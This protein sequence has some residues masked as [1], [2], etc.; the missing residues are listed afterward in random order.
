[1]ESPSN[2]TLLDFSCVVLF[3]PFEPEPTFISTMKT[4]DPKPKTQPRSLFSCGFF[5]QWTP[6][7]P[8][9]P[10]FNGTRHS[11]SF[12]NI[13]SLGREINPL[14][15]SWDCR[16]CYDNKTNSKIQ[17]SD[18]SQNSNKIFTK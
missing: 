15:E 3:A 10:I 5:R 2:N 7:P 1:M 14:N 17:F 11:L 18:K 4:H 16:R 13:F 9:L 12:P 6:N 8:S